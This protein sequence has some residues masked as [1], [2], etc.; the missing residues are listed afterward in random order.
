[1][2][3]LQ[4]TKRPIRANK[5]VGIFP[6]LDLKG[7][8]GTM[9]LREVAVFKSQFSIVIQQAFVDNE[10]V[11]ST[12]QFCCSH[13]LRVG[14]RLKNTDQNMKIIIGADCFLSVSVFKESQFERGKTFELNHAMSV[15]Q[16]IE[17]RGLFWLKYV[18]F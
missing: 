17:S 8:K 4:T 1:M 3:Y 6:A 16:P 2:C 11:N 7:W 14:R 9:R 13:R 10:I 5:C 15:M 12:W 18:T